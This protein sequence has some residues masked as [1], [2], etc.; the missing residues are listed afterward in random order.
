MNLKIKKDVEEKQKLSVT[1]Q[2][3]GSK[4]NSMSYA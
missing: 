3:T 2:F 4:K 1:K